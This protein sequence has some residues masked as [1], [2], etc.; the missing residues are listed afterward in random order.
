MEEARKV[1]RE[2][3][4]VLIS[5]N[6]LPWNPLDLDLP[7]HALADLVLSVRDVLQGGDGKDAQWIRYGIHSRSTASIGLHRYAYGYTTPADQFDLWSG[8]L[9]NPT[10]SMEER[11]A[12]LKPFDDAFKKRIKAGEV[13]RDDEIYYQHHR[14]PFVSEFANLNKENGQTLT[15]ATLELYSPLADPKIRRVFSPAK[16]AVTLP[17]IDTLISQGKLITL[18]LGHSSIVQW[19]GTFLKI[20]YQNAVLKRIQT[21][22]TDRLTTLVGDE[23]QAFAVESNQSR[24]T[25]SQFV[26]L[27]RQARCISVFATQSSASLE[28]K[29]GKTAAQV[30]KNNLRTKIY[31]ALPAA[32]EAKLASDNCGHRYQPIRSDSFGEKH[33]N[34]R[35]D[36]ITDQ[37]VG[38]SSVI[39]QTVSYTEHDRPL[40]PPHEFQHLATYQAICSVFD[41]TKQCKPYKT[42][43]KPYYRPLRE[44]YHK[45]QES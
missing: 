40:F 37:I 9:G 21:G 34:T 15:D 17:G 12:A 1:G 32:S 5:S 29:I 2:K 26:A 42:Y 27:C 4:V 23:F 10:S 44:P 41:G 22:D 33:R 7:A 19:I 36:P 39:D 18:Q 24:Y 3:D 28:Q 16:D 14:K 30:L 6:G 8:P 25:D 31:M 11:E 43:L 38:K 13:T 35:Y 20:Q 45:Q